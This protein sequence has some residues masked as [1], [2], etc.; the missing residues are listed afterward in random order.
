MGWE[1][2]AHPCVVGAGIRGGTK[3]LVA[4]VTPDHPLS[5]PQHGTAQGT[6]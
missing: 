6:A 1:T 2:Q 5:F 4:S 3:A